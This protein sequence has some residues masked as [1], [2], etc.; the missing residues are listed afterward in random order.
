MIFADEGENFIGSMLG[1]G[2]V[3]MILSL[4]AI[5]IACAT[6]GVVISKSKKQKVVSAGAGASGDAG[7]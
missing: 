1:N 6:F 3:S 5:F 4:L 7:E 2:N